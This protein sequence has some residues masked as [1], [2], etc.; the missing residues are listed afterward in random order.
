MNNREVVRSKQRGRRTAARDADTET[1]HRRLHYL[2]WPAPTSGGDRTSEVP[3]APTAPPRGRRPWARQ[4]PAYFAVFFA[5]AFFGA[6][7]FTAFFGA[8]FFTTF[9]AAGSWQQP[10]SRVP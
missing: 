9:F 3:G 7:F 4:T 2:S 6:A 10:S 8:A 1:F 5:A